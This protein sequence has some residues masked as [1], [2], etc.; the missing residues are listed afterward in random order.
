MLLVVVR[1]RR[2]TVARLTVALRAVSL[3]IA[4]LRLAV[5]RRRRL[6]LRR[7]W[8]SCGRRQRLLSIRDRRDEKPREEGRRRLNE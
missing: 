3:L 1:L 8:L 5:L 4:T 7:R 6:V 2:R